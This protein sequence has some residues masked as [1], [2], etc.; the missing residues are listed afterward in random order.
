M[1]DMDS[2]LANANENSMDDILD[3]MVDSLRKNK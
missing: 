1:P 2:T 3:Q